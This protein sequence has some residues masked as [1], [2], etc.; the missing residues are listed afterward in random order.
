MIDRQ[1]MLDDLRGV[2]RASPTG[3]SLHQFGFTEPEF[4]SDI[5]VGASLGEHAVQRV[6]LLDRS[7]IPIEY[8]S[9]R[10]I[11]LTEPFVDHGVGQCCGHQIAAVDVTAGAHSQGCARGDVVPEQFSG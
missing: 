7:W 3:E 2:V 6:G 5:D 8:E 9:A 10:R 11:G 4:E 1:P